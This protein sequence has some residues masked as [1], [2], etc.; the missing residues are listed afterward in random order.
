MA[1]Q[2][3]TKKTAIARGRTPALILSTQEEVETCHKNHP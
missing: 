3:G 2:T 1:T